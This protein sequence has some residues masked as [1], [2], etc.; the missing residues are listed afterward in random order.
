MASV[1]DL[2]D[3]KPVSKKNEKDTEDT[4]VSEEEVEDN[5]VSTVQW[6]SFMFRNP[7]YILLAVFFI[8]LT[9]IINF[10]ISGVQDGVW[11]WT[12]LGSN[13]MTAITSFILYFFQ[14]ISDKENREIL[15]RVRD[16]FKE[17][18]KAIKTEYTDELKTLKNDYAK[19]RVQ[20]IAEIK[21]LKK[22]LS[23]TQDEYHAAKSKIQLQE[24]IISHPDSIE[25]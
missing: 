6:I 9:P 24:Y 10:F 19:E 1:N 23:D 13:I 17:Q 5:G 21:T 8:S 11:V 25:R 3:S 22:E 20:F 16:E 7:V 2:I 4:T 15:K 14:K 12:T 18:I